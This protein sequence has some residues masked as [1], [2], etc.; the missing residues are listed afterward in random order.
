MVFLAA[1]IASVVFGSF[2]PECLVRP[3]HLQLRLPTQGFKWAKGDEARGRCGVVRAR[4][5]IRQSSGAVE[6]FVYAHGPSGSGRYWDITVGVARKNQSK[7]SRGL[8]LTTSTLGWRTLQ[9]KTP[10]LWLDDLDNDGKA[11][12]IIWNSFPIRERASMAEYGLM[13]WV[14]RVDSENSLSLDWSL[15]R[16]MAS[17]IALEYRSRVKSSISSLAPLRVAAAE[18]LERFAA[19]P[20]SLPPNDFR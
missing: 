14:Y 15:T 12:I 1:L 17:Q 10:L 3:G 19:E 16:K 11:E 7:P 18:A 2:Q 5:W 20:C 8:C 9:Q 4:Q 6:L 13:A